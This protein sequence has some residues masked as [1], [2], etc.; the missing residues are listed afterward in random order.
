MAAEALAIAGVEDSIEWKY[1]NNPRLHGIPEEKIAA[2][3]ALDLKYAST[4][5]MAGAGRT[6]AETGSQIR[7][8]REMAVRALLTAAEFE[9]YRSYHSPLAKRLQ[10]GL[11]GQEISDEAY[12]EVYRKLGASPDRNT[13]GIPGE[14]ELIRSS[15]GDRSA[16]SYA[17]S[18]DSSARQAM[19][20]MREAGV[21]ESTMVDCYLSFRSRDTAS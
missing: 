16:R 6:L 4:V 19:N 15:L 12:L 1:L 14:V 9:I 21:P 3:A 2:L 11:V 10:V 5:R 20:P 18:H 17:A 8:E 13:A 7:T